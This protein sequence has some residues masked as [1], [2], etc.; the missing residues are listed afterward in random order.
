MN[1]TPTNELVVRDAK[2]TKFSRKRMAPIGEISSKIK[3]GHERSNEMELGTDGKNDAYIEESCK[4]VPAHY[5]ALHLIQGQH[6][7]PRPKQRNRGGN[8]SGT[9][10]LLP[11]TNLNRWI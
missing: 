11:M 10:S 5:G 7:Q 2:S 6:Q 3:L 9:I 4:R 8:S 1:I